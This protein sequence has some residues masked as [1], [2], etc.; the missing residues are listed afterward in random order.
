ME[1]LLVALVAMA[2]L[3]ALRLLRVRLGHGPAFAG[4]PRLVFILAFVLGPPLVYGALTSSATDSSLLR[5]LA[6]VP[7]Y[8]AALVGILALMWLA[9]VALSMVMSGRPRRVMLLALVGRHGDPDDLPSNPPLTPRLTQ[10]VALV[11]RANEAFSRGVAFPDEIDRPG[12][13]GDWDALDAA[14]RTLEGQI[15]ED[16]AHGLGVANV[17]ADMSEDA[18]SRLNTLRRLAVHSERSLAA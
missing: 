3:A 16:R 12:F 1:L 11:R 9:A 7:I 17:A 10:S 15:A 18:R 13:R 5:G 4:F 14:T 2:S 6:S 8:A